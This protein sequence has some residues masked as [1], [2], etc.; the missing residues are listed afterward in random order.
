[1]HNRIFTTLFLTLFLA[2]TPQFV[3][4]QNN[5]EQLFKQGDAAETVGNNSQAETIWRQVLQVEPNNGKAYNNLGN[6]L[7]RQGKLEEALAAH[8]KALQLNPNDAEAY[9]GIGNVLDAQGKQEEAIA[10][11]KKALQ[12]NPNLAI[13]Y[14]G[15]GNALSD[16]KKL[17]AAVAAY[18]KAIQLNP[19][20]AIAYYN[21][22]NALSD[23]KKLDAAVAAYQKAIQLNRNLTYAYSNL[24]NALGEQKKLD[25]AVA[26]FQKALRL[27]EDNS[28]TPTTAHTAA[29]NGLGLVFEE[30][31]K[32]KEA[33]AEF[34]ESEKIDHT[35]VYASNNN[36]KAHRLWK[37]QQYNLATSIDNDHQWLPKNDPTVPVKRSVVLITAEFSNSQRQGTEIGTGVVIKRESNRT[38]ILTNRHV[39]FDGY[40]QGKNIQV[41]FFSSPPSNRVRMGRDAK[42]FK[43]TSTDEQLD[44]AVLE[45]SGNLPEDIQPLPISSTAIAS[46]I[47]IRIIGHSAEE[48]EDK[49]W[50][51]QSGQ[52]SYQNQQ[53]EISQAAL[54]PGYS[55]SPVIDSQ[56]KLLG[57]VFARKTV[58]DRDLAYPLSE[59]QKQL[60]TWSIT[61]NKP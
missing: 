4:A 19:N 40:E 55:G 17:D 22:G 13:A 12:L 49:S 46:K 31:S 60:L 54:K 51:I 34:D 24:G 21:L 57:I 38:L 37:E 50:S 48:G 20:Y 18:Q 26:A 16:Q 45:V 14:N 29:H 39:I 52:I 56:N 15:L 61:L 11:H 27:P 42:L 44:L 33:I 28:G 7:R 3:V 36:Y 8:Q 32:L 43:M 9:V 58:E 25:A 30:Q 1:M 47:P 41:E 5:I 35:Y 23:Q 6:A 53:L 59:I 2:T 10:S